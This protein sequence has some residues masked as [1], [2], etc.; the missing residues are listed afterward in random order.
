MLDQT[1]ART[2][3]RKIVRHCA[4]TL[5]GVKPASLFTCPAPYCAIDEWFEACSHKLAP[6]G[7]SMEA[8]SRRKQATLVLVCRTKLVERTLAHEQTACYLSSLGYELS[9]CEA[10]LASLRA[11]FA[12]SQGSPC[13]GSSFPHE[14][15]LLLGYPF[16]DV[17][18][19]IDGTRPCVAC[20]PWKAYGN[21]Q[22]ACERFELF[23]SCTRQ[24][25]E[26]FD[27]G[28][29]IESLAALEFA[30]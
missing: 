9:S 29:D 25:T 3:D 24:L 23:R 6:L 7:V 17:M 1:T 19:F 15:G 14:I 30:A 2:L 22:Q 13:A 10:C 27:A 21:A 26:R 4:P 18:G 20:G 5:V 28:E 16:D 12:R 8:L 11:R